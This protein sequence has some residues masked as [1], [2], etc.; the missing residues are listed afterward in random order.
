MG[1]RGVDKYGVRDTFGCFKFYVTCRTERDTPGVGGKEYIRVLHVLCHFS[2]GRAH[3]WGNRE[4]EVYFCEFGLRFGY[5]VNVITTF[6]IDS[7]KYIM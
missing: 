5:V 4:S 3:S 6:C 7:I 1:V 2:H